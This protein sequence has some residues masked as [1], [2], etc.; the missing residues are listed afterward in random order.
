VRTAKQYMEEITPAAQC[1]CCGYVTLPERGEYDICPVCFWEDD[2]IDD[3]DFD[4]SLS[5]NH[6][7]L[8]Q[9]RQNF[10]KYGAYKNEEITIKVCVLPESER[11]HFEKRPL[12]E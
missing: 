1:P 12:P 11:K 8:R 3:P 5:P 2:G 4:P 9:G 10:L 7:T 6:M